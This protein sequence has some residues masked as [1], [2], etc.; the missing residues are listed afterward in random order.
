VMSL[1]TNTDLAFG[2]YID[3]VAK[4]WFEQLKGMSD[5][6]DVLSTALLHNHAGYHQLGHLS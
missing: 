5:G 2:L 4:S 3:V 1:T 6:G